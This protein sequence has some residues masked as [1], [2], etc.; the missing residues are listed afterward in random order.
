MEPPKKTSYI[1]GEN[2][3]SLKNKKPTLK[4]FLTLWEME[5]SNPKFEK[6]LKFQEGTFCAQRTNIS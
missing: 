3:P 2:F 5:L 4:K 1:S 6:I